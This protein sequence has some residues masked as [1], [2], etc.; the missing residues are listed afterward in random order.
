MD[1]NVP[2]E[3]LKLRLRRMAWEADGVLSL[4]FTALDGADLPA[5]GPGAHVDL[6]LPDGVVRQYS[7]FGDPADRKHYRVAVREVAGGRM[8]RAIHRTFRPGDMVTVGV[9]RN[10]FP[11]V[12]SKRY[13]FVAG[14]IGITPLLPMMIEANRA[15]A[16][17]SLLYC[18]TRLGNAPFLDE[19]KALGG[20]VS[21]HISE[22]GTRLD[23]DAR[24]AER[25]ADTVLY[26]C[27]PDR[28]MTAVE[29]ATAGWPEGTVHFEWFTARSRPEDETSGAFELFCAR[30]AITL[31]VPPDRSILDTL[32]A[33]G[34]N[35]PRSCEQ[36]ICGS[37]ECRIVEGAVDHRDSILSAS[38]RAANQS[39]M[40]CVSRAT[41][42]RLVLDI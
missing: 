17:W 31:N 11:L 26:C 15:G 41:G 4:D 9:P 7:L 30:S 6:H 8:S 16:E 12:P 18:A 24:L 32:Q 21:L 42:P 13:L 25:P 5:F 35:V 3:L 22:A 40:T 14:G 34:I 39:L 37:C 27:G 2:G 33:A 10:N 29:Q 1:H 23:V 20:K 36:G 19:V 28:L 38:E